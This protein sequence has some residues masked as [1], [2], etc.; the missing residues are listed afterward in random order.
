MYTC[1][2]DE[3]PG[4]GANYKKLVR[5]YAGAFLEMGA[6]G[7]VLPRYENYVDTDPEVKDKWGIP[8]LRFHYKFGDNEKKMAAD[9]SDAAR[10][11]FE[12]AGLEIVEGKRQVLTE[13]WAIHELGT[14]RMGTDPKTPVLTPFPPAPAATN[15]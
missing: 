12:Q 3:T 2:A 13:G 5:D 15:L 1:N 9:M 4:Y 11:M 10:D 6:F 14:A 8:A 7:E